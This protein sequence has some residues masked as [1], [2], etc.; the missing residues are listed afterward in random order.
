MINF[1]CQESLLGGGSFFLM[2]IFKSKNYFIYNV[3]EEVFL[4]KK[5]L[6]KQKIIF[7]DYSINN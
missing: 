5:I 7:L 1:F 6:L 4:K 3:P 2:L